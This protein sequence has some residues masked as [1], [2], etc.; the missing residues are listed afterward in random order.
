MPTKY[1][2]FLGFIKEILTNKTKCIRHIR[3]NFR[4]SYKPELPSSVPNPNH[5]VVFGVELPRKNK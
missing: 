2:N 1:L 4:W 5:I 3:A